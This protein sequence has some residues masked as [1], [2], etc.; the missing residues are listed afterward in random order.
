[1]SD[2][3]YLTPKEITYA[4]VEKAI[5]KTSYNWWRQTLLGVMAGIFIALAANAAC[6]AGYGIPVMGL[7][8]VLG[9][10][11]FT[12]GLIMVLI[13]GGDLFTGNILIVTG[14][15]D[16]KVRTSALLKNWFF[17]YTGNFIGGFLIAA[18]LI[19]T[20]QLDMDHG[21][22]GAYIIKT[23][24]CKT[25][26]T[27]ESAFILGIMCNILVC[28][29]VWISWGAKDIASKVLGLFVP[30]WI[31]ITSG[32]EH[33]VAN[34]YYIVQGLFAKDNEHYVEVL[35]ET[36][37]YTNKDLA[38]L[39]WGNFVTKNL[40]PVTLGNIVG[41]LLFIGVI[42]WLIYMKKNKNNQ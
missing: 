41:G 36:Y 9:G 19:N 5:E 11:L 31:F 28:A 8:K 4:S 10:A 21:H 33:C 38:N 15:L 25:T 27:F 24:I 14:V 26:L 35:K 34:M 39:T 42:Y 29:A 6:V 17:V 16:K 7:S 23:A 18:L 37:A 12:G 40:I 30:I 20:N 1:M 2:K 22:L 13:A 32:Y 3:N